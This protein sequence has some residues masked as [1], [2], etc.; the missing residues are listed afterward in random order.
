[1]TGM[2]INQNSCQNDVRS[3][4]EQKNASS[5]SVCSVLSPTP[6][7]AVTPCKQASGARTNMIKSGD[8]LYGRK[9]VWGWGAVGWRVTEMSI[10]D[11][12]GGE[13]DLSRDLCDKRVESKVHTPHSK[14]K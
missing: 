8:T 7:I 11:K 14:K 2:K 4:S 9:N 3:F 5:Q 13:Q 1:M 12:V 6:T 10:C